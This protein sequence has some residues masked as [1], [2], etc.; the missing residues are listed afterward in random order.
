MRRKAVRAAGTN[1]VLLVI[2][3]CTGT[4]PGLAQETPH[5]VFRIDPQNSEIE[6]CNFAWGG[7]CEILGYDS[8]RFR[9]FF[10]ANGATDF[11]V[12]FEDIDTVSSDPWFNDFLPEHTAA[13][14]AAPWLSDDWIVTGSLPSGCND[15]YGVLDGDMQQLALDILDPRSCPCC[16]DFGAFGHN[17]V[18]HSEPIVIDP[19]TPMVDE[20]SRALVNWVSPQSGV[21]GVTSSVGV[22]GN[23]IL[24]YGDVDV[25]L[26]P[27]SLP[28]FYSFATDLPPLPPGSYRAQ[29]W[30]REMLSGEPLEDYALQ[31][32]I[33]F[34]V[35]AP[36]PAGGPLSW[37]ILVIALAG[38]ALFL[39]RQHP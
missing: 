5:L 10:D 14:S 17:F 11:V 6:Y 9:M 31:G 39:L 27:S 18:A 23:L 22:N 12:W 1:I 21:A 3:V 26:S 29:Y 7:G 30:A 38:A 36:I 35:Q 16:P 2:A 32:E 28:G 37:V 33:Q 20:P 25:D 19:A 15:V 13:I 24:I 4:I 8:G 34:S